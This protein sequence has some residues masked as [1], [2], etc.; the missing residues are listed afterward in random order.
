MIPTI[1][2]WL[3]NNQGVVS[4]GLFITTLLFGWLSG[5]FASLRRNPK[6]SIKTLEGPTFCCT[7][8]TGGESNNHMTHQTAFALYLRISN[9]GSAASSIEGL[10]I[11]YHWNLFPFSQNWW[12]YTVGW[13]WLDH[14]VVALEDFQILIGNNIKVY[15]FFFQKNYLSQTASNTFLEP[16]QSE[17]GVVYFEQ[18]ES[19][20][21]CQPIVH[22]SKVRVRIQVTDVFGGKHDQIVLVPT[23]TLEEARKFNPSFGKTHS[24][25]SGKITR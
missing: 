21:G 13:F 22:Q 10:K 4:V 20:G 11:A 18:P 19:W 7:Y 1:T 15:P 16:G 3:N 8:E 6:F 25:M 9:I 5:I 24:T 14:L 12:K 23:K 2:Q 17:I